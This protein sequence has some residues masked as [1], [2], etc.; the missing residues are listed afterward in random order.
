MSIIDQAARGESVV[1]MM[2]S[3]W[4]G[5]EQQA[6]KMSSPMGLA[7]ACGLN[8]G[9]SGNMMA[10]L[11]GLSGGGGALSSIGYMLGMKL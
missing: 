3:T 2:N 10:G 9:S 7:G 11:A 4:G 5:L 8:L 1:G 6:N